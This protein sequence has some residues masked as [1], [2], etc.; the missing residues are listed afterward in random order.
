MDVALLN[1]KITIQENKTEVDAI[2]NHKNTWSDYFSCYATV[3]GEGGY[4]KAVAGLIVDDSDISFTVRFC[5]SLANLDITKHR[6]LFEGN[7]YNLVN[8]DHMNYKKKCL[9]L[10]CQK[11]RK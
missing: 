6:V 3:S 11:V 7:I 10:K 8:I 9:K 1:V 4:E 2:G 5:K